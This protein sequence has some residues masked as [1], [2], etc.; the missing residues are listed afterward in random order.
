MTTLVLEPF[1]LGD[2]IQSTALLREL[3]LSAPDEPLVVAASR[4]EVASACLEL[5]LADQA[6]LIEEAKWLAGDS[7]DL[8]EAK[9]AINLSS[10]GPSLKMAANLKSSR[11]VKDVVGPALQDGRVVLPGLQ[12]L[13]MALMAANRRL[14]TVNLVDIWRHLGPAGLKSGGALYWPLSEAADGDFLELS[15]ELD[16][17]GGPLVGLHLGCGHHLRRWPVERFA[18]LAQ[19][20]SPAVPVLLGGPSERSL[21]KRFLAIHSKSRPKSPEPVNLSGRTSLASL[22]RVLKKLHLLVCADTS[23]MHMAAALG[24]PV[25]AVFGG[26]A[27]AF[28]TGPYCQKALIIQGLGPCSPCREI[29]PCPHG[30]CLALP[31][32]EEVARAALALLNESEAAF[33][34]TDAEERISLEEMS[35]GQSAPGGPWTSQILRTDRDL[36]GQILRPAGRADPSIPWRMASAARAAGALALKLIDSSQL[37]SVFQGF[38]KAGAS[39]G[40]PGAFDMALLEK[41][42]ALAFDLKS[43]QAVFMEAAGKLLTNH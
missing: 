4:S 8:G 36:L 16:S 12:R 34:K 32:T 37:D 18:S 5:K 22:A 40:S 15:R 9:M 1:K 17:S 13:A 35:R 11:K 10:S 20:L 29:D 3:K 6:A 2:F 30:R 28:E 41:V 25:A 42:A 39:E 43:D 33:D 26:P 23:V 31:K 7:G 21:A 27:Y 19:A 14:G 24:V 38:P